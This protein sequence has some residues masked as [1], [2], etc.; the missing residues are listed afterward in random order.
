MTTILDVIDTA[1]K[2]GL[3][4]TIGGITSYVMVLRS[5][6]HER[7][8]SEIIENKALVKELSLKLEKLDHLNGECALHFHSN[9]LVAAKKANV[10]ATDEVRAASAL[11]NLIGNDGLVEIID[12]ISKLLDKIYHELNS[13]EPSEDKLCILSTEIEGKKKLAYPFLRG[14]YKQLSLTSP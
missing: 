12:Q 11:A 10:N 9:D 6:K 2:I 1:V 4:A 14:S 5:Q 3:G 7:D 8:T 13:K